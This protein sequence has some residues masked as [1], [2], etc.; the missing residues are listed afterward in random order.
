MCPGR[1]PDADTGGRSRRPSATARRRRGREHDGISTSARAGQAVTPLVSHSPSFHGVIRIPPW[2]RA[3]HS[4]PSLPLMVVS[5]RSRR[6]AG[7]AIGKAERDGADGAYR[8][9]AL[10]RVTAHR[11]EQLEPPRGRERF[12]NK[13]EKEG[14]ASFA[15]SNTCQAYSRHSQHATGVCAPHPERA[16][17]SCEPA[18]RNPRRR[19]P[20][21]HCPPCHNQKHAL[22]VGLPRHRGLCPRSWSTGPN[23]RYSWPRS[24]PRARGTGRERVR[25]S[26]NAHCRDGDARSHR[27]PRSSQRSRSLE[28]VAR[29]PGGGPL[30]AK[31]RGPGRHTLAVLCTRTARS[32][33]VGQR[34]SLV[35]QSVG[36]R[37]AYRI[38]AVS[39]GQIDR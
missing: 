15:I 2:R 13:E 38:S 4:T 1:P 37:Y 6:D 30:R 27:A 31:P 24:R 39:N 12:L 7:R 18:L 36:L 16:R 35:S 9:A 10:G 19:R 17:A 21:L 14:R 34:K 26:M 32:R 8:T 29:T 3:A 25:T 11:L 20:Q 22:L 23:L 33:L 28:G 5:T